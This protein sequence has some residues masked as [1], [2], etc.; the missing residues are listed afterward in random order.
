MQTEEFRRWMGSSGEDEGD[1][2][3]IFCH[4]DPGV[5]KTFIR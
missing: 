2:S 5:G 3:V 4:G 1:G